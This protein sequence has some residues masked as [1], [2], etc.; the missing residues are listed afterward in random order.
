MDTT[1][2]HHDQQF[3]DDDRVRAV[4][5][6]AAAI[7]KDGLSWIERRKEVVT[8]LDEVLIRRCVS[9]EFHLRRDATPILP[10]DTDVERESME[11]GAGGVIDPERGD[12]FGAPIFVLPKNP[13]GMMG[14]DLGDEC[15]RSLRL[16]ARYDN[17]RISAEVLVEL[18]R[19]V[20]V[21]EQLASGLEARLRA[22]ATAPADVGEL[23]V[24]AL[25]GPA[26]GE[27]HG[28]RARR[29]VRT[30]SAEIW[31]D[32]GEGRLGQIR[33]PG[34]HERPQPDDET[35]SGESPAA[36]EPTQE[37][38][39]FADPGFVRWLRTFAHSSLVVVPFRSRTP[40]RKLVKLTFHERAM[41]DRPWLARLGWAPYQLVIDAPLVSARSF[42]LEASAPP[43]LQIVAAAHAVA[44]S[45]DV[46]T[47]PG[48]GP[49][50]HLYRDWSERAGGGTTVLSLRPVPSGIV[51]G[52]P[53]AALGVSAVLG[54]SAFAV[55]GLAGSTDGPTLLLLLPGLIASYLARPDR[56]G[57]TARMHSGAR[58][59]LTIAAV[60]AFIG[61]ALVTLG[62]EPLPLVELGP[63]RTAIVE[64]REA[65]FRPWLW[66]L[67]ALSLVPVVALLVARATGEVQSWGWRMRA[68]PVVVS[69]D[70]PEKEFTTSGVL[71]QLA[72]QH[73]YETH[74]IVPPRPLDGDH[75]PPVEFADS[76]GR[77][78]WVLTVQSFHARDG[79]PARIEI[80][81]RYEPAP[82]W[83]CRPSRR[84]RQRETARLKQ[85]MT[86][87][88]SIPLAPTSGG[89]S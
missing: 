35:S 53:L 88:T 77:G 21:D 2:E 31:K 81:S 34:K 4:G 61:A 12:L 56:H 24:A 82:W 59:M 43:G 26:V 83:P 58:V 39:L 49:H 73:G 15:G 54:A 67:F 1:V 75:E 57:L 25:V 10:A 27:A 47:S 63:E 44:G 46:V 48:P 29:G 72:E 16:F 36:D 71:E 84:Q 41:S 33:V 28:D 80:K 13:S 30:R 87:L 37:Q 69:R 14:F 78:T 65:V 86:A 42:H 70:V 68:E 45:D 55:E 85:L 8:V 50:L 19:Q 66:A 17:A 52:A 3:L 76:G 5:V 9:V 22:I 7:L 64:A 79:R 60:L 32:G 51:G 74:A 62:G 6:S 23:E 38:R 11:V 89:A 20:L 18:A 40:T